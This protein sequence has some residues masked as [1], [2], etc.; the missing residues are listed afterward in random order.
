M[1]KAKT[2]K[3]KNKENKEKNNGKTGIK[4]M[5][6]EK[7]EKLIK[8]EEE[9]K[10]KKIDKKHKEEVDLE[11]VKKEKE[12]FFKKGHII[13]KEANEIRNKPFKRIKNFKNT[14]MLSIRK[15]PFQRL[16]REISYD[17]SGD[18]PLRYTP[19]ALLALHVASED[20][21]VALFEDSYLCALHANRVTL[22]K[23]DLNL[24]RRIR[25]N[26]RF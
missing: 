3:M 8:E 26:Y 17:F 16:V 23:K 4:S 2:G 24:A 1:K 9:K 25:G 5:V 15:L 6:Q 18:E 13:G 21:L 20:Y 12:N 7:K 22:M 11:E 14:D 10:E 19:Q